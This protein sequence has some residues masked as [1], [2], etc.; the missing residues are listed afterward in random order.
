M[1]VAPFRGDAFERREHGRATGEV[2][3]GAR[4]Y[5][6]TAEAAGGD[7]PEREVAL[8]RL[9]AA[10]F[11]RGR[12]ARQALPLVA[13]HRGDARVC[14]RR[15]LALAVEGDALAL[16]VLGGEPTAELEPQPPA[17]H[18]LDDEAGVVHVR[19]EDQRPAAAAT[20]VGDAHVAVRVLLVRQSARGG[21]G[22][23]IVT[24][25]ALEVRRGGDRN[26]L[27]HELAQGVRHVD[28]GAPPSLS[29]P[30]M[31]PAL[32]PGRL[33]RVRSR[34]E[35]RGSRRA[36]ARAPTPTPEKPAAAARAR[37]PAQAD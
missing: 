9:V 34:G 2:V 12:G 15:S 11:E 28:H 4:L 37:S 17:S 14:V 13:S 35:Q 3:A 20:T 22:A 23:Q 33:C 36:R 5:Q 24:H 16:A 27:A 18:L 21:E 10:T 7:V 30:P 26:H 25:T 29:A 19:T 31:L 32:A 1:P 6:I 8:G